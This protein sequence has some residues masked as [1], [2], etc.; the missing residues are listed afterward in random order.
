MQS[1]LK[2]WIWPHQARHLKTFLLMV[3]LQFNRLYELAIDTSERAAV[4]SKRIHNIIE[5]MTYEIYSYIQ[6]GLFER[7]KIIFA[8]LLALSV[9]TSA[10]KV[11]T[12]ET[13]FGHLSSS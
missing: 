9:L 3:C 13:L 4:S 6:R 10:G 11:S 12:R 7:H 2:R 5:H 8:L 1:H